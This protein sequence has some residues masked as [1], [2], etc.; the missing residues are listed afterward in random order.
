MPIRILPRDRKAGQSLYET[1]PVEK[2]D[3]IERTKPD[4][5]GL[6]ALARQASASM[7][8]YQLTGADWTDIAQKAYMPKDP[9]NWFEDEYVL[10][11]P[12]H[13][14]PGEGG[15]R[16]DEIRTN[17]LI[18]G[19]PRSM[20][21]A[22]KMAIGSKGMEVSR[23]MKKIKDFDLKAEELAMLKVEEQDIKQEHQFNRYNQH[24]LF[25]MLD[26]IMLNN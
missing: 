24:N 3:A 20:E 7:R 9:S 16:A 6:E 5:G 2:P 10:Q 19:I 13:Y 21:I 11:R 12:I 4:T 17:A 23:L 18:A 14:M 8:P 1:G 25:K 15:A 26:M 22:D